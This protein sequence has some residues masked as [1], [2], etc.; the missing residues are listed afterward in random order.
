MTAR[1]RILTIRLMEKANTHPVHAA[2]FGIVIVIRPEWRETPAA[3]NSENPM[4][5]IT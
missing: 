5:K 1:Q 2:A 4:S 3:L